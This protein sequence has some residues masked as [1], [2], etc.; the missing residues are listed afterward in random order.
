MGELCVPVKA[1]LS[2]DTPLILEGTWD[3]VLRPGVVN[4]LRLRGITEGVPEVG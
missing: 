1:E 2:P 3:E 4:K